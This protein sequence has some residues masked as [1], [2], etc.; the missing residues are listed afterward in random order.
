MT[1]ETFDYNQHDMWEILHKARWSE[2]CNTKD[3]AQIKVLWWNECKWS[4]CQ[5]SN[6]AGEC[7]DV[8]YERVNS[9]EKEH[10]THCGQYGGDDSFSDMLWHVIGLGYTTF[11]EVMKDPY[12]LNEIHDAV[13]SFSYVMIKNSDDIDEF[14]ISYHQEA[15]YTCLGR[16][17]YMKKGKLITK[18][19]KHIVKE[20]EDR[21]VALIEGDVQKA[22]GDFKDWRK[23]DNNVYDHYCRWENNDNYARFSNVLNDAYNYLIIEE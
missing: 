10:R 14:N 15:A 12:K 3:T 22:C 13:E 17:M 9:F 7:F 16:L 18:N 21:F 8:L 23:K 2:L 4:I 6:F 19:N 5:A 11:C 1:D 20:L